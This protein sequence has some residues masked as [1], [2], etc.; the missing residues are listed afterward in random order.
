MSKCKARGSQRHDG[1][2]ASGGDLHVR[3]IHAV[4]AAAN[5]NRFYR[6]RTSFDDERSVKH[7]EAI[8]SRAQRADREGRFLAQR[9]AQTVI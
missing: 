8:Q 2:Q 9:I 1:N 3:K 4:L 5:C 7:C 6:V